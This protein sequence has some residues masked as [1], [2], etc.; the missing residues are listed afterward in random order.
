MIGLGVGASILDADMI[1]KQH[2]EQRSRQ[3]REFS[4]H[5]DSEKLPGA[6]ITT[7]AGAAPAGGVSA[8]TIGVNVAMG[9]V[10]ELHFC[11]GVSG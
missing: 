5:A 11:N 2:S 3:L 4:A 1:V 8:A 6:G 9:G 10:K 7:P